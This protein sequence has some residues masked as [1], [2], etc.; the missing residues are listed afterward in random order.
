MDLR[1]EDLQALY[2]D[3]FFLVPGDSFFEAH[4]KSTSSTPSTAEVT[5]TEATSTPSETTPVA[6]E[7]TPESG[8]RP[9]GNLIW[10]PKPASKVLFVLHTEEFKDKE[11][12]LLLKRIVESIQIPLDSAG[13]GVL[14]GGPIN[15]ADFNDMPNTFAVIFDLTMEFGGINPAIFPTGTVYFAHK[16]SELQDSRDFKKELWEQLKEIHSQL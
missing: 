16:L 14:K 1:A 12:A 2:G 5:P 7:P 4:E 10:K 9:S 3:S 6:K 15:A 13:F 8:N 11:L